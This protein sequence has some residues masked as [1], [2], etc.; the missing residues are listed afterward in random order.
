M[1]ILLAILSQIKITNGKAQSTS[2]ISLDLC[3]ILRKEE[4]II[5]PATGKKEFYQILHE[6]RTDNLSLCNY[7]ENHLLKAIGRIN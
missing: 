6:G 5:R 3:H 2:H 7:L 1:R 4:E